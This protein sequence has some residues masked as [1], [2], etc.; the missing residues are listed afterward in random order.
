M[1]SEPRYTANSTE[2]PLRVDSLS[3][4]FGNTEVL[5][6][7]SFAVQPGEVLGVAGPNGCGKTTLVRLAMGLLP[8]PR[9]RV[10]VYG[11][12]VTHWDRRGLAQQIAYVP[13]FFD[14]TFAF[15]TYD[16]VLMGRHPHVRRLQRETAKDHQITKE[17]MLQASI[18]DFKARLMPELSGGEAQRVV[19]A[20]SIAQQPRLLFTDEPTAHL[21]IQYQLQVLSLLHSI[22]RNEGT[23]IVAVLHD[24]NH[25]LALCDRVLILNEGRLHR[26]G[27]PEEVL[28]AETIREVFGIEAEII[29]SRF[30]GQA[31]IIP[32]IDVA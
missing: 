16:S 1:E 2:S 12:N 21:D 18:W 14:R 3:W 8:T 20:R 17:A 13:Q 11:R 19:V 10:F 23:A 9:N 25:V 6:D 29:R 30:T 32:R 24:L 15:T 7:L 4:S 28:T 27:P 31:T 26:L 22:N 5:R